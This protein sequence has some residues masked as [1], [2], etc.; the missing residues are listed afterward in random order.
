MP[1]T[2]ISRSQIINASKSEV[3]ARIADLGQWPKWS[4]WL[5][6]DPD[7]QVE[8]SDGGKAYS[9][10]GK[11]TGEGNMS[12]LSA[13]ENEAVTYDLNFL[14]PFKSKAKVGMKLRETNV[15]TEVT[16]TMDGS[17][18]WF[19][20][21]MKNMM[22]TFV[23]MDYERGLRLL[24]DYVE[25]GEVHS[26][27]N[28]LGTSD[29]PGCEYIGITRNCNLDEMGNLMKKDFEEL[30]PWAVSKGL[31]HR[32]GFSIYHKF[33]PIKNVCSYTAGIAFDER[34]SDIPAKYKVSK[35]EPTTIYT[36]EHVGPY[37]H[38]GNAWST[39]Q[40]MIRGK[41]VK[42]IKGYHP[43]ETYGN[44]P[45]DTAPND[46]VTRVNFAVRD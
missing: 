39:M 21:W 16:W 37:E 25:D 11:R 8:V 46:L 34:P 5:I 14:K 29:Y 12:V 1:K 30:M 38:L 22:Q 7:T 42:P 23:G 10:N 35:M 2:H 3:Y 17:L 18:P 28:F 43:F 33:D 41:E 20:F 44:S 32:K 4:P 13:K 36:I 40:N 9:W 24:K 19:M 45:K 15:G 26:K 31:D 27:L 6:M